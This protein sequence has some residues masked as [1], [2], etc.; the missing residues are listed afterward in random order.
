MGHCNHP[1]TQAGQEAFKAIV[2]TFYKGIAGVFFSFAINNEASLEG[3]RGWLEEVR[4]HAHEEV[5]F[6]LVGTK[7][8][9]ED[10][11]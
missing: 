11:R 6:F 4:E 7:S 9:L 10:E 5:V 3:I 1:S 2:R 8:D